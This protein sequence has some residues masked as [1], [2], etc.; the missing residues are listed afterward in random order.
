MAKDKGSRETKKPKQNKKIKTENT[1][2]SDK[3]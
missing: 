2:S 3:K 1:G